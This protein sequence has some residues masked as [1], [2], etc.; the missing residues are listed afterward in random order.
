MNFALDKANMYHNRMNSIWQN[1]ATLFPQI[2]VI[3]NVVVTN[4]SNQSVEGCVPQQGRE[5]LTLVNVERN[6]SVEPNGKQL[7]HGSL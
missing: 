5:G 4:Q 2:F 7:E 3:D 1:K 6:G